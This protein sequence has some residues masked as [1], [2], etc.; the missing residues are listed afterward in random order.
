MNS[1]LIDKIRMVLTENGIKVG[2]LSQASIYSNPQNRGR[3]TILIYED[4]Q[5]FPGYVAKI[6]R[7]IAGRQALE[8]EQ[9]SIQNCITTNNFVKNQI[10]RYYW[11]DEDVCFIIEPYIR[12]R[13]ID[14]FRSI[15][16]ESP[17]VINWLIQLHQASSG[18]VWHKEDLINFYQN[19]L[20]QI[21]QYYEIS[22]SIG[23]LL[24]EQECRIAELEDFDTQSTVVHGDL[25]INNLL[26][27]GDRVKVFDWEWVQNL[28]WPFIDIWFFLFSVSD[29]WKP[30]KNYMESG[31]LI[32]K[33]FLGSSLFS[34]Y[35]KNLITYYN[36][37]QKQPINVVKSFILLTLLDIIR[38]D[39]L[40]SEVIAGRSERFF[41]ILAILGEQTE[42]YWKFVD[43]F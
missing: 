3:I 17:K 8:M 14:S 4:D 22:P 30:T 11:K 32:A 26:I 40:A 9:K 39:H 2:N 20:N 25:T 37:E 21:N 16:K 38:R 10:Q 43:S 13:Q 31:L 18:P 1:M 5:K 15:V 27:D 19:L 36:N 35:V 7:S 41:T 34:K 42:R 33:T 6:P 23:N 28:G 29:S 24:L 12:G